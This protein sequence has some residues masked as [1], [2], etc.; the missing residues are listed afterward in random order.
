MKHGHAA[1][2][3]SATYRTWRSMKQRCSRKKDTNNP[4]YGGRGITVCE[5]WQKFDNFLE[6]MGPKPVGLTLERRNNNLGYSPENC[7]WASQ[8]EQANNKRNSRLVEY[9]GRRITLAQLSKETGI[10]RTTIDQRL[11]A[12]FTTEQAVSMPILTRSEISALGNKRRWTQSQN[13]AVE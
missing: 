12:G 1:N 4:N 3:K 2:G 9:I 11:D 8:V 10:K 5:R 7:K 6:D 13:L